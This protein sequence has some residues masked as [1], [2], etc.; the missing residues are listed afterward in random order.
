MAGYVIA[1][2]DVTNAEAYQEYARQVPATIAKYGGH[3]LVRAGK[4]ELR[5]GEWP[6]TR[7]VILEFVPKEDAMV[8]RL[9]ASRR[10]VFPGYTLEGFRAAAGERFEVVHEAPIEDS[11]RV[12]FLLR[13]R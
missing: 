8:R 1:I 5:E 13:R 4:H 2:V 9:L 7:T 12:L 3:Y 10:D 6:G 11:L